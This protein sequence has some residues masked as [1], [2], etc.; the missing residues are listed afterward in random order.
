MKRILTA[1]LLA[2]VLG[3]WG[4]SAFAQTDTVE[5]ST[6]DKKAKGSKT[7]SM[8]VGI[9]GKEISWRDTT[10]RIEASKGKFIGGITFTRIDLGFSRLIDNGS[11]TL[12]PENDFL[13]YKGGKTS[14]FSFDIVQFGYRFNQ[15]FKIYVAGGFDWTHI[16]LRKDITIQE[17]TPELTY[18]TDDVHFSK[19]RF[20]SSYV[21]I[22]L[23]FELRTS[24]NSNGKRFYFIAGP[25]VSFL[26]NG[27]VKQISEERGKQK[28]R[29]DYNFQ[30]FRY[31]GSVRFGYN[32]IGLF[33]KVYF[34]DMFASNPQ[35]GLTNMSFGLTFG[36]N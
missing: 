9:A 8:R 4:Q 19:N 17:N 30:V 27:K 10:K 34:N 2:S 20:S 5:T 25:E 16:R 24:E 29:D 1:A 22:P 12:S 36:L 23:N 21:H 28:F 32:G 11:F 31:G 14:T 33:T 35:K 7:F 3:L 15:N 6:T 18:V 13:D 26:L